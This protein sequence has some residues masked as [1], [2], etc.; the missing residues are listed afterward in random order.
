LRLGRCA[1]GFSVAP[2]LLAVFLS[3][4]FTSYEVRRLVGGSAE[5]KGAAL[6]LTVSHQKKPPLRELLESTW[7]DTETGTGLTAKIR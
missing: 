3:F 2:V 6:T 5:L 7:T 4:I 1:R